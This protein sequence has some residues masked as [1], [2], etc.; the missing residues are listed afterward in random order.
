[1]TVERRR[2]RGVLTVGAA[3]GGP[4][5]RRMWAALVLALGLLCPPGS[6]VVRGDAV[7]APGVLRATLDNGLRVVVVKNT[8]APVVTTELTYLVGSTEAPA[9]FPGTAHA[10]EHMM[11]R[12]SPDLS[13]DQLAS[14]AAAMGGVRGRGCRGTSRSEE[15]TSEL[16]SPVHL[17]C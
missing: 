8:L 14:I 10:L 9:G 1:M 12:G 16:Q 4:G 5:R 11:F 3:D 7:G 2:T 17:V 15:H 6:A 13:A